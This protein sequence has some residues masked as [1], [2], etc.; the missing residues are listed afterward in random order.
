M[1]EY[2]IIDRLDS[3]RPASIEGASY[4][5]QVGTYEFGRTS[6]SVAMVLSCPGSYPIM[7]P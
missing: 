2:L 6:L 1:Q 7:L 3:V 5:Q 4:L